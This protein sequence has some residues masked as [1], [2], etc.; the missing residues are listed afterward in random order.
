[1]RDSNR[2]KGRCSLCWSSGNRAKGAGFRCE[3]VT[4]YNPMLVDSRDVPEMAAGIGNPM[5]YVVKQPKDDKKCI[6]RQWFENIISDEIP[7]MR[8]T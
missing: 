6:V 4:R 8:G 7:K 5:L 1:M 3:V 2:R